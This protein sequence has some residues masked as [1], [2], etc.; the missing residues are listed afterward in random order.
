MTA[1]PTTVG[2][3]IRDDAVAGRLSTRWL[4]LGVLCLAQLVVVL[5][6]TVLTVAVPALTRDLAASTADIQWVINA[7]ALVQSGLLLTAGSVVDRYG[8]RRMLLAGLVLFG[9]ASLAA[10]AAQSSGQLIAARAALGVG[11]ALLVTGTLAVAM[12]VFDAEER[13]RA[14]GIWAAVSALG[15]AAG[16]PVG[17]FV[18][19]HFDWPAIF[20]L[21]V[22]V[23][24]LCLLAGVL[25]VPESRGAT[26]G[27]LDLVGAVLSTAGLTAVVYAV[28]RGPE[29]GWASGPVLG[30]ALA[31]VVLVGLFVGWERRVA[32]PMLDMRLFRDRRFVG[33]VAGVV[34]ITF[35]SAGALFL[36]AQQ[37]QFVRGHSAWEAGLRTAPFALTVVLLNL[38]GVTA[39]LIRTLGTP[40]A[41]ASGMAAL[42]VG[43]V[44]AA[45]APTDGY[46][47]L[48]AGLVLMGAGCAVANPAIVAAVMSAIPADRAGA[49]AGV[50]GTMAEVGSSLGVAVLGAVMNA[51]F[52]AALPA[53]VVGAGSFPA[54]LA[55]ARDE[56]ERQSVA[57]AF[58]SAVVVGQTVG[59]GAVLVGGCL[60]ALLL[61]H[62]ARRAR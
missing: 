15:F 9:L 53:A 33:A 57:E 59:A 35:G 42:A 26:D 29:D 39:R 13:P 24:L 20:L 19:A 21:N 34:L 4:V 50:D 28:I 43:L 10:A 37:L 41:I 11:G 60:A 7:Y 25:L 54:A 61:H 49:G 44:V 1:P 3:P 17:G 40:A 8:R 48:L 18:L 14:I 62:A 22:P 58:G 51:R 55:A 27:R 45:H 30:A 52:T 12:Q 6:N 56:V 36:L 16:P 23:V 2:T 38:V 32:H 31:G 46:G 5:D 47:V